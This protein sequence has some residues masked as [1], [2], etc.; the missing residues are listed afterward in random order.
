[1]TAVGPKISCLN[2]W[3]LIAC[4]LRTW[5]PRH[6]LSVFVTA[7]EEG[8]ASWL[9]ILYH[10]PKN[11]F[12]ASEE[13]GLQLIIETVGVD[14]PAYRC[15]VRQ[16]DVIVTVDDW[17]ITV[18]DRPQVIIMFDWLCLYEY[19]ASTQKRRENFA[20][21]YLLRVSPSQ[22]KLIVNCLNLSG[23]ERGEVASWGSSGFY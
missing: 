22:T 13:G 23:A 12:T 2:P 10:T 15:G 1:M 6:L 16:G 5:E 7:S 3:K 19:F 20:N 9:K 21:I 8:G 11:I 14:S 17:L 4:Y 18:M